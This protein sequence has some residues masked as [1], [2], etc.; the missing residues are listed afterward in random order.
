MPLMLVLVVGL[1]ASGK[2]TLCRRAAACLADRGVVCLHVCYDAL[3]NDR[4]QWGQPW[5]AWKADRKLV[6]S[7]VR[8]LLGLESSP[9]DEQFFHSFSA[10]LP[11]TTFT[12]D[13]NVCILLD[14]NFYL[15]SMRRPFRRMANAAG[16][17]FALIHVDC[18]AAIAE[19]RNAARRVEER[20]SPATMTR[21]RERME[22]PKSGA[23]KDALIFSSESVDDA[24]TTTTTKTTETMVDWL[25]EALNRPFTPPPVAPSEQQK[26][27]DRL[28]TR[29]SP[30]HQVDLTLRQAVAELT[31]EH[32]P[33]WPD[34]G[35][36]LAAAKS[37]L[38][39]RFQAGQLAA[40]DS[41]LSALKAL[42]LDTAQFDVQSLACFTEISS[43]DSLQMACDAGGQL[44]ADRS[45]EASGVAAEEAV[46]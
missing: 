12:P 19:E 23:E 32:L 15:A 5:Y 33:R 22:E 36:R 11:T 45:G 30:L 18:P 4:A 41:D 29:S 37:A 9:V 43:S 7:S 28:I 6:E 13:D 24:G 2:T 10:S 35:R 3:L 38:M 46:G 34:C 17:R 16:V 40:T 14:D 42:L 8:R 26:L 20:V 27:D 31:R 1:P 44:A 39:R 25:V 21:M